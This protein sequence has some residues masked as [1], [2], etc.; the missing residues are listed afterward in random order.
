VV[1][2]G[3]V[4]VVPYALLMVGTGRRMCDTEGYEISSLSI[5]LF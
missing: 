2:V 5:D 4:A 3:Y 1:L